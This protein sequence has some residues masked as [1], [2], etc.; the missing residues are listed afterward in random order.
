MFGHGADL[1]AGAAAGDDHVIGD[2]AFAHQVDG[3]DLFGLVVVE[4]FDDQVAQRV[5]RR[6]PAG[7][8]G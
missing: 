6:F 7:L 5:A 8:V 3:G 4:R 2:R 1:P